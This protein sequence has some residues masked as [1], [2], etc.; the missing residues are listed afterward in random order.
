MNYLIAG[1]GGVGGSIAAFLALGGKDVTCIARGAHLEAIQ[2]GY[3]RNKTLNTWSCTVNIEYG[4][5]DCFFVRS[6][7][8]Q[9]RDR[10]NGIAFDTNEYYVCFSCV[11]FCCTSF[12]WNG[13]IAFQV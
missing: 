1:T 12:H 8:Y 13:M 4:N 9:I 7:F 6:P 11:L 5:Y 3:A 2:N 10:V